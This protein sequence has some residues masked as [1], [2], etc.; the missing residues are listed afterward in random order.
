MENVNAVQCNICGQFWV[1]NK[2]GELSEINVPVNE[3]VYLILTGCPKCCKNEQ[4]VPYKETAAIY[5]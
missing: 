2:D 4:R 5:T 3:D 1:P